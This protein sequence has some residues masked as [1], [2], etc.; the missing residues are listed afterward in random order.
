MHVCI[1]APDGSVMDIFLNHPQ[2]YFPSLDISLKPKLADSARV[3]SWSA[4][5]DSPILTPQ[6]WDYRYRFPRLAFEMCLWRIEP[7][8]S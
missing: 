5:K 3:G 1:E 2:S 8:S 6:N 7:R 4:N